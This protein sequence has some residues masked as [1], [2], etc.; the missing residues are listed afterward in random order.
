MITKSSFCRRLLR[1]TYRALQK[2]QVETMRI[3]TIFSSEIMLIQDIFGGGE[4]RQKMS[5]LKRLQILDEVESNSI[6]VDSE[7]AFIHRE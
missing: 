1:G 2:R 3:S 7:A 4:N 5:V 6:R